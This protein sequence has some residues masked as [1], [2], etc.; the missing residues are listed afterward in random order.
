LQD[1]VSSNDKEELLPK[2][3]PGCV[4][5]LKLSLV[6]DDIIEYDNDD[7]EES[8]S[9]DIVICKVDEMWT[10]STTTTTT[11]TSSSTST[12]SVEE[13]GKQK[14]LSTGRLREL[15]IITE[16]GRIATE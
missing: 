10:T 4:Q 12:S 2:V 6:G 14:Y 16:Q 5:Y 11:T 9:H 8:S 15:G 3:L 7:G 1:L 13:E